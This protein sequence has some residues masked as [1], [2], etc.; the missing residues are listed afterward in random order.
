MV[1]F[2]VFRGLMVMRLTCDCP[3]C[4]HGKRMEKSFTADSVEGCLQRAI[5]NGNWNAQTTGLN[6]ET[7]EL[8]TSYARYLPEHGHDKPAD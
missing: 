6:Y 5:T 4:K 2:T 1:R 3:V 7:G 8:K